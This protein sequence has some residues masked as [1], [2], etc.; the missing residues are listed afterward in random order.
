MEEEFL[1][2]EY[3]LF[4]FLYLVTKKSESS[5]NKNILMIKPL[6]KFSLNSYI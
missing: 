3:L 2:F 4:E 1:I 5:Q 6:N